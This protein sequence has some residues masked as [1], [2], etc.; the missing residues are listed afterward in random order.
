[1]RKNRASGFPFINREMLT[2]IV[3]SII[4]AANVLAGFSAA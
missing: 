4:I 3:I 2:D 1:M